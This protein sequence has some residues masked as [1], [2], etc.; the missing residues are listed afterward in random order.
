MLIES[1]VVVEGMEE[2]EFS[3]ACH[4][5]V[6]LAAFEKDYE[7]VDIEIAAEGDREE[8]GHS[9]VMCGSSSASS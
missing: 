4:A 9:D 8:E 7:E 5:C 3:Q 2:C 1:V 6:D